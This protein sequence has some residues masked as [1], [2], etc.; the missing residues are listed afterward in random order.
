MG[1]VSLL[2]S[3]I[4]QGPLGNVVTAIFRPARSIGPF[5][6]QVTIEEHGIDE[7]M[8]TDHPVAQNAA[9]TDHSYNRPPEVVIR[10]GFSNSSLASLVTDVA[11]ILNLFVNGSVGPLNYANQVYQQMLALQ[12][13]RIPFSITTGKRTYKNM[14]MKSIA[15]E[16]DKETENVLM[17][18][19][20][21]RGV[22]LVQ[23]QVTSVINSNGTTPTPVDPATTNPVTQTGTQNLNTNANPSLNTGALPIT[24]ADVASI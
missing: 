12:A 2:P 4:T 10:C 15:V 21:C 5:S 3:S 17:V 14:L 23:T 18:T 7:L 9:I 22:I 8:I 13:S 20:H 11:G 1:L 19:C 16:T 24:S 6:T